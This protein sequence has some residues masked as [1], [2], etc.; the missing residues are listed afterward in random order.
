MYIVKIEFEVIE[1][2]KIQ[3]NAGL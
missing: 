1:K 3:L 2:L